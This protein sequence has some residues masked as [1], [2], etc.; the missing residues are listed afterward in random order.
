M[1]NSMA[2][3]ENPDGS[4]GQSKEKSKWGGRRE[5]SGTPQSGR[6]TRAEQFEIT[7]LLA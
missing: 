1:C 3:I 7:R 4:G 6:Q 5:V 2:K